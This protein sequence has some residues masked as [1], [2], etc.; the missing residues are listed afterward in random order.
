VNPP[1]PT[2]D[3][4]MLALGRNLRARRKAQGLTLVQLGE[5]SEL[6]ATFISQ[7]ERG[8][9]QPSV[10][11]LHRLAKA[12]DTNAYTMLIPPSTDGRHLEINR[13]AG[14]RSFSQED[15]V[16]TSRALPL[17]SAGNQLR[18]IEVVGGPITWQGPFV[19]RNDEFMYVLEGEIEI[20]VDGRTDKLRADDSLL[21]SGGMALRW[22]ALTV[23][24]RVI[25]VIVDECLR[26]EA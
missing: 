12:L 21:Y 4:Q 10:P 7:V 3:E 19:H 26:P 18:V 9:H 25:V 2:P 15:D 22:R 8:R 14:R 24:T 16:P 11:T 23:E 17:V 6:S 20:D 13:S 5:L 1:E